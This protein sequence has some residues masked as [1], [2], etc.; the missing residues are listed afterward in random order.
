MVRP[1][2]D[3]R[4]ALRLGAVLAAPALLAAS[5]RVPRLRPRDVPRWTV[6]L[7]VPPRARPTGYGGARDVYRVVQ[8]PATVQVLPERFP[9]TPVWAYDGCFPGPTFVAERGRPV[10]VQQVNDL[11]EEVSTHLHGGVNRSADDGQ[12]TLPVAPGASRTYRYD[13][14]QRGATLWYHDHADMRTSRH[15]HRGLAGVYVVHDPAEDHLG[16][17]SGDRD[18]PLVLQDRTFDVEG[19]MVYDDAGGVAVLGDVALVNG[20]AWPRLAVQPRRYRFRVLVA[21][22]SRPYVLALTGGKPFTVVEGD[23][24]LLPRPVVVRSLPVVMA[25]RYGLVV[26]FSDVPV[27]RSVT[28]L[29]LAASGPLRELLRFD[30]VRGGG[31]DDSRVPDR[32]GDRP[33]L[34]ARAAPVDRVWRFAHDAQGRFVINGRTYD[35]ARVDARPRLGSVEVWEFRNV[36]HGFLH[37]VHPHLVHLQVLSRDGGPPAPYEQGWK[38]T[39]LVGESSVVRV[40][41]RFGPHPGRY[42][43]HCHDLVHEDRSMMTTFD[44]VPG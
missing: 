23:T 27:G 33:A 22:N 40:A 13:N 38:D 3:R 42:V 14:D 37:P 7:P 5:D 36:G 20:A 16:L 28:L 15:V 21:A 39:V 2:V 24:G 41:A 44:V 31:S 6:D 43:L 12:P 9:A 19:R 8:R 10:E 26:D 11:P 1:R 32:L 29:D 17:P 18:L 34:A 35:P 25:E 4:T 30:V